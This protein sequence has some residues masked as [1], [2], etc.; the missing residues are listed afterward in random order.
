MC[1]HKLSYVGRHLKAFILLIAHKKWG[2]PYSYFEGQKFTFGLFPLRFGKN[3]KVGKE[4]NRHT[5]V[6]I[7]APL[8]CPNRL[9]FVLKIFA[10][11]GNPPFCLG[12]LFICLT[13]K[14]GI[15]RKR[16]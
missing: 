12:A 1:G 9:D 3:L 4:T 8:T 13:Q 10:A 15:N 2:L 16:P 6:S 5:Q 7:K 14:T 11:S